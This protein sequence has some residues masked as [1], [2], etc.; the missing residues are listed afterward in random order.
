MTTPFHPFHWH[1]FKAAVIHKAY[2]EMIFTRSGLADRFLEAAQSLFGLLEPLGSKV[3][4]LEP[5][6]LVLISAVFHALLLPADAH[7]ATQTLIEAI[8]A[9]QEAEE[10]EEVESFDSVESVDTE[11]GSA[12]A[13]LRRARS[14]SPSQRRSSSSPGRGHRGRSRS[15]SRSPPPSPARSPLWSS[16]PPPPRD[17]GEAPPAAANA[18]ANAVANAECE[19]KQLRALLPMC[20]I[21]IDTPR[22]AVL[23][24]EGIA[25]DWPSIWRLCN[26]KLAEGQRPVWPST[27]T[28][29]DP[30]RITPGLMVADLVAQ[31]TAEVARHA[32]QE[33]VPDARAVWDSFLDELATWAREHAE[34]LQARPAQLAELESRI[35]QLTR[36]RDL[37]YSPTDPNYWPVPEYDSLSPG[38]SYSPTSPGY[39]RHPGHTTQRTEVTQRAEET[40][41][42]EVTQRTA[43]P[44]STVEPERRAEPA[45]LARY[46]DF[47]LGYDVTLGPIANGQCIGKAVS[48]ADGLVTIDPLVPGMPQTI[49]AQNLAQPV[50]APRKGRTIIIEGP[51]AGQTGQVIGIDGHDAIVKMD[52]NLDIKIIQYS[53]CAQYTGPHTARVAR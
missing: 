28:E 7:L 32:A 31:L 42:T 30:T 21:T 1:Q 11:R 8:E 9:L 51:L 36:D 49:A 3:A 40:Q 16:S 2:R 23:S 22:A 10:A 43:E 29:I 27:R 39:S 14:R 15:R 48:W 26:T 19:V 33:P 18:V 13:A 24:P 46:A 35:S 44:A 20:P 17:V 5:D 12:P 47:V 38:P 45:R 34:A 53:L 52:H 50:L 4:S 37:N 25:Y 6:S 41:M